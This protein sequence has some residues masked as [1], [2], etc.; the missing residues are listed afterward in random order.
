MK[1]RVFATLYF[2]LTFIF[3]FGLGIIF[4]DKYLLGSLTL[5]LGFVQTY[6][7]TKAKWYE[8]FVG[9]LETII[10]AIVCVFACMYG[11]VIFA[12]LICIPSSIFSIINWKKNE[13]NNEVMLNSMT[14]QKSIITILIVIVATISLSLLLTL[15][16]T[17]RLAVFDAAGDILNVC[18]I[19]LVALRYKEG[20]IVWII[21]NFVDLATWITAL[22]KDYSSNAIMM[23]IMSVVYIALNIWGFISF[24]KLRKAQ[25]N[26]NIT[27]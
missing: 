20:M 27:L 25:E 23:I 2:I 12:V 1:K 24:I 4:K 21:C 8:E 11:N 15:I 9:M 17:Q 18:G 16:P 3:S 14:W 19:I 7:M 6:L 26:K 5:Y 10:S 13:K 22:V